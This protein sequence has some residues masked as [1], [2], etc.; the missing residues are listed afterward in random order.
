M[1]ILV[2]GQYHLNP[3]NIASIDFGTHAES[4]VRIKLV[5]PHELTLVGEVAKEARSKFLLPPIVS[6]LPELASETEACP[7]EPTQP[8]T[9]TE[10]IAVPS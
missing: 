8:E 1:E 5:G 10:P 7:V 4:P 9:P 6:T 2:I 3:D